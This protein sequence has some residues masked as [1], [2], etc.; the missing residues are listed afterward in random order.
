MAGFR[1][2]VMV[3]RERELATLRELAASALAGDPATALV[4][5]EA[6]I[7]KTRLVLE[8]VAYLGTTATLCPV[9]RGVDLAGEELSFGAASQ[10]L[11]TLVRTLGPEPVRRAAGPELPVLA[12]LH[13]ALAPDATGSVDPPAVL[14]AVQSL[15]ESLDRPVCWVLDDLQ[16]MDGASRD[17][18]GYL[19]RVLA[20]VPVLLLATVRTTPPALDALP[21]QLVEL[22]RASTVLSLGPLDHA[23]VAAQA[24]ALAG[25]GLS[26]EDVDRIA[27]L[28]DGVPF[29][30]EQL[31]ASRADGTRSAHRVVL[32]ELQDVSAEA[33]RLLA[34]AAVGEGL[35]R[36]DLLRRVAE[37]DAG[38]VDASLA[39]LR[40]RGVLRPA[41]DGEV[42]EFR[43]ALLREAVEADLL[44]D[45]R[46][47]LH[48]R[49]AA[50]L[51]EL[52]A[53][54][55]HDRAAVVERARHHSAVGGTA[56]L[57]AVLDAAWAAEHV[58][59]DRVRA[60]WWGR[61]LDLTPLPAPGAADV[62]RDLTLA[63]YVGALWAT[64]D[65]DIA[66][67]L[68]A[69]ELEQETDWL[70][71]L[72]LDLARQL[73][74]EAQQ[75]AFT[76]VLDVSEAD[77]TAARL[78]SCPT[79]FR[80]QMVRGR[81]ASQWA[82]DRP[83]VSRALLRE[84][85]DHAD[86]ATDTNEVM[87]AHWLLGWLEKSVENPAAQ[88]RH[89]EQ[90][91]DWLRRH[92]T[93]GEAQAR[94]ML[95]VAWYNAG[96]LGTAR[97]L[98]EENIRRIRG[99][100]LRPQMWVVQHLTLASVSLAQGDWAATADCL[101]RADQP[102]CG[103]DLAA[104]WHQT[105]CRLAARQGRLETAG[106][107]LGAI[108]LQ[109][110]D[111]VVRHLAELDLALSGADHDRA[112]RAARTVSAGTP[113][114]V[115]SDEVWEAWALCVRTLPEGQSSAADVVAAVR[116]DL[117]ARPRT[118]RIGAAFRAEVERHLAAP[119][120]DDG[121]RGPAVADRWLALG[122]PWDAAWCRLF[123]AECA[124]R[125]GDRDRAATALAEAW[126]TADRLGAAPLR[127]RVE[128]A[129]R[130]WRVH[131][132]GRAEPAAGL[133]TRETE[134]LALLAEGLTNAQIAERLFMSPKT[135]SV[136]VSHLIA[137]L[138]VANRTEAAA[139]AHRRGLVAGPPRT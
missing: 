48:R 84:L 72:W 35:L 50:A 85:L 53:T 37:P 5:G 123:E 79:D 81:L 122:R 137:K 86:S 60:R 100:R 132:V 135:A 32:P 138:G 21:D 110:R 56:A 103:G 36:P 40:R 14:G 10:L 46:R 16:W 82:D 134:V 90:A 11:R 7:G 42:L 119:P 125:V 120:G 102:N 96:D 49:W 59:D 20:D 136:H 130:Q 8:L 31:V 47:E 22:G 83:D 87:D 67:G 4:I 3:G 88:P 57:A 66:E 27:S 28:S 108:V 112:V 76:P 55:P 127:E 61:A 113:A 51:D 23:A 115:P 93:T 29:F 73:T 68:L 105:A 15:L 64:G 118:G 58:D 2:E 111:P 92:H 6:G 99:P 69:R 133:T 24:N 13:P 41:P 38:D 62:G 9:S 139:V 74:L 70:R 124:A 71:S 129:A 116:A 114:G 45:E 18:V 19:S 106:E 78:A 107:D 26:G 89:I 25:D 109:P 126:H 117:A 121:S 12:A 17:L 101:V 128:T 44:A 1:S 95:A 104:W 39:D 94:G 43:H 52:V 131:G 54:S 91:I 33:R 77:A 34:A 98:A 97:R 80:V 63:R 65:P 30:V 75:I